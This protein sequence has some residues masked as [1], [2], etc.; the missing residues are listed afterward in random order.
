MEP[1]IGPQD[2]V[3]AAPG[4][5]QYQPDLLVR[6]PQPQKSVVDFA[7]DPQGPRLVRVRGRCDGEFRRPPFRVQF[8]AD[9]LIGSDRL[10]DNSR[11][12]SRTLL[13][14]CD[15]KGPLPDRVSE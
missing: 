12:L 8:Q 14:R 13:L 15:C 10:Q 3:D 11:P 5:Q 7:E 1:G 2:S 9:V 6:E 4:L